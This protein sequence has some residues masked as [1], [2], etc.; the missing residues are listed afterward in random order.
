MQR[1]SLNRPRLNRIIALTES[2]SQSMYVLYKCYQIK[3]ISIKPNSFGSVPK[4][5]VKRVTTY[6]SFNHLFTVFFFF[7]AFHSHDPCLLL[8]SSLSLCDDSQSLKRTLQ[9]SLS[10]GSTN[11][12]VES[13]QADNVTASAPSLPEMARSSSQSCEV[14]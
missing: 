13:G 5:S 9:R 10:T 12:V 8:I 2:M 3:R 6:L 14:I 4:C 1:S 7:Q 11:Q